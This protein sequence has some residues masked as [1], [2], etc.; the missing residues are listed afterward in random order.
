MLFHK[1]NNY[2]N[3][4]NQQWG[5]EVWLKDKTALFDSHEVDKFPKTDSLDAKK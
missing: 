1:K 4:K 3:N 5:A 2:N